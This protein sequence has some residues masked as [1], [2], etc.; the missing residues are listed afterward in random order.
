MRKKICL[1]GECKH[2]ELLYQMLIV[3]RGILDDHY[4]HALRLFQDEDTG[5]VRLQASV[6]T[7]KLE[8]KPIWTAFITHQI[9]SST[10]LEREGPRVFH[11]ADLQQYIFSADYRPPKTSSGQFVLTFM[12]SAGKHRSLL[13]SLL[14]LILS[15]ASEFTHV[16][17]KLMVKIQ[18]EMQR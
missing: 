12:A 3:I 1:R 15:D 16:L 18:N 7:G 17:G 2:Y 9:L 6:H 10:W 14:V 11:L 13:A 5:V 4:E 8:R